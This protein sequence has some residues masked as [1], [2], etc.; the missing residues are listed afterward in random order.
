MNIPNFMN[1]QLVDK[2]GNLTAD[3]LSF[4]SQLV[5][6]LDTNFSNEGLVPPNQPPDNVAIIANAVPLPGTILIEIDPVSHVET[7][8]IWLNGSF[9]TFTV[10]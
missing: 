3:G 8:K 6:E 7:A 5:S 10:T 9:K 1:Y 4:F 2:E